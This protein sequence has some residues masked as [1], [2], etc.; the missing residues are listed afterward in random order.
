VTDDD[1]HHPLCDVSTTP[2]AIGWE[3]TVTCTCAI[4]ELEEALAMQE[5]LRLAAEADAAQ[6]AYERWE[7]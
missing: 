2:H 7:G 5:H 4:A 6:E 3:K 1:E